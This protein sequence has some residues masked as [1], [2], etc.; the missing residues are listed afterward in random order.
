VVIPCGPELEYLHM[1]KRS[2]AVRIPDDPKLRS[3]L[4]KTGA[5]L[6]SSANQPGQPPANTVDEATAYFGDDVDFY[7]DG[8]DLSG[9]APSTVIRVIDDAIEILRAGA[10]KISENGEI[11]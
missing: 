1:G 3:L 5:L 4:E 7:V 10:V 8:G 2:L 11:L 9:H 6:T